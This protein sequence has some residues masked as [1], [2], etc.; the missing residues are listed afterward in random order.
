MTGLTG[1]RMA[2]QALFGDGECLKNLLLS[3]V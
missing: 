3:V 2:P 1:G